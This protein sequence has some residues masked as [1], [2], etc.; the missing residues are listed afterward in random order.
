MFY[1]LLCVMR[2]EPNLLFVFVSVH[3]NQFCAFCAFCVRFLSTIAS[4]FIRASFFVLRDHPCYPCYP[5]F[6]LVHLGIRLIRQIRG[7]YLSASN[8][9]RKTLNAQRF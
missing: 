1:V 7:F 8:V 3:R 2:R 6:F 9:K 4:V 5:W